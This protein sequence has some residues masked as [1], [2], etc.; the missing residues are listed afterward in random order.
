MVEL[1]DGNFGLISN[2]A[3]AAA[4]FI[5]MGGAGQM[6]NRQLLDTVVNGVII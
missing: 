3:E 5:E 1:T 6:S 2:L 4:D